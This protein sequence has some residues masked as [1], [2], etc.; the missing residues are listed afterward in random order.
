MHA[1]TKKADLTKFCWRYW[2]IWQNLS[3][4]GNLSIVQIWRNFAKPAD[5][6]IQVD[7]DNLNRRAPKIWRNFAKVADKVIRI[8]N[9]QI[10]QY[11][12]T[13]SDGVICIVMAG[14]KSANF[15]KSANFVTAYVSEQ[16]FQ[17]CDVLILNWLENEGSRLREQWHVNRTFQVSKVVAKYCQEGDRNAN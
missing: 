13:V 5:K 11:V 10:P 7:R 15:G 6:I 4:C 3:I 16:N 2:R 9:P 14:E 8:H 17:H 1:V 12:R